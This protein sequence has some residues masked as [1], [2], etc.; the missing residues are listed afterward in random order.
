VAPPAVP[1]VVEAVEGKAIEAA[2]VKPAA[3]PSPSE[4]ESVM[5]ARML[6]AIPELLRKSDLTHTTMRMV[7]QQLSLSFPPEFVE[8]HKQ[9][10]KDVVT[11]AI[12]DIQEQQRQQHQAHAHPAPVAPV[13]PVAPIAPVAPLPQ[14]QPQPVSQPAPQVPAPVVSVPPA[15][16][17][18]A[19]FAAFLP[20]PNPNPPPATNPFFDNKPAAPQMPAGLTADES[21][22]MQEL[23]AMGF[24]NMEVNVYCIREYKTMDR[25]L[26]WL[27]QQQQ[28]K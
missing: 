4:T 5:L 1:V 27:L 12:Q 24:N 28:R 20:Q 25:I 2:P 23:V 18:P 21:S 17:M 14:P 16:P 7:R 3:A 19:A 11:S 8:A 6:T 9:E 15:Q 22:K 13:A 26:D 10:I